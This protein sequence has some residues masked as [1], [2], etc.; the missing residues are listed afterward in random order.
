M[1][2]GTISEQQAAVWGALIEA[3]TWV[4]SARVKQLAKRSMTS[5][6]VR[7]HLRA[8][9]LAHLVKVE[10]VHPGYLYQL[11]P[12]GCRTSSLAAGL[13]RRLALMKV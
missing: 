12:D 11:D 2:R 6:C 9:E 3:G 8:F 5:R 10:K 1:N 7:A 13:T 4:S